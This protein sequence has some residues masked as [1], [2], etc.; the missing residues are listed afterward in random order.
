MAM[1][2]SLTQ[3]LTIVAAALLC[4]CAARGD[5]TGRAP[6]PRLDR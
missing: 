5:A 2:V 4:G 6:R 1:R 3:S